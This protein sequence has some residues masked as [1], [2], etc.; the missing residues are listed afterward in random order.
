MDG[1]VEVAHGAIVIASRHLELIFDLGQLLLQLEKIFVG[2]E[3]RIVLSQGDQPAERTLQRAFGH[4]LARHVVGRDAR[5]PRTHD[6]LEQGALVRGIG[7]HGV[8][9][10][11]DKVG[12]S[13][14]LHVDTAPGFLHQVSLADQTIVED[15]D[16]DADCE[17]CG[18]DDPIHAH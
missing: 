1:D 12:A 16:I 11:R 13:A 5:C 15:D 18:D 7:L 3:V 17:D 9:Q 6:I 2:L 8:D 14:Q 4:G 10:V